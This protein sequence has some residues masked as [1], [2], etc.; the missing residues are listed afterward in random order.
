VGIHLPARP[1]GETTP[2][3]GNFHMETPLQ[4]IAA[5]WV[6]SYVPGTTSVCA[7]ILNGLITLVNRD[8]IHPLLWS[9]FI[10]THWAIPPSTNTL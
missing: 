1:D 3:E 7:Y 2:A 4:W 10:H 9:S 5:I 8:N 6:L